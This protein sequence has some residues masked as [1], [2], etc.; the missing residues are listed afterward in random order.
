MLEL[1][2][3]RNLATVG[4]WCCSTL[5]IA[6]HSVISLNSSLNSIQIAQHVDSR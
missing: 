5:E 2:K 6:A 4:F 3:E 1:C